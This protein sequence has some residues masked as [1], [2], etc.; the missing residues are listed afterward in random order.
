MSVCKNLRYAENGKERYGCSDGGG[1]ND[2][3]AFGEFERRKD[4]GDVRDE[5]KTSEINASWSARACASWSSS[6]S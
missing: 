5:W 4:A 2:R 3:R 6:S 1:K